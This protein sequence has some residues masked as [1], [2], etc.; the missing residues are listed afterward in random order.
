MLGLAPDVY[1]EKVEEKNMKINKGAIVGAVMVTIV[2]L[3]TLISSI[4]YSLEDA[5]VSNISS[6]FYEPS[7]QHSFG[8]DSMGRDVQV[9]VLYGLRYSLGGGAVAVLIALVV[10]A[11]V[12]SVGAFLGAS[13]GWIGSVSNKMAICLARF[14]ATGPAILLA[15]SSVVVLGQGFTNTAIAVSIVLIP[16]YIRTFGGA[17][18]SMKNNDAKTALLMVVAQISL[19]MSLAMLGIAALSFLGFGVQPP[20]PEI[21]AMIAGG[22]EYARVAPWL[23]TY[24]G[25]ALFILALSFNILGNG[26]NATAIAGI[27]GD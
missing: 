5:T 10:G 12:G 6:R 2:I 21:G 13:A 19:S 4:A 14:L 17:V 20:L 27:K 23:L 15:F 25:L 16:G 26:L 11:C 1:K 3:A 7:S 18:A 8:T 22:R 24:P 9:R